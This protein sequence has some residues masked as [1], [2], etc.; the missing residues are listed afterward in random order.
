MREG[1]QGRKRD[2]LTEVDYEMKKNSRWNS[3]KIILL[4]MILAS[5]TAT[6]SVFAKPGE[7]NGKGSD[8]NNGKNGK[9][10]VEIV[11]MA[12][13]ADSVGGVVHVGEDTDT[14]GDWYT[15]GYGSYAHILPGAPEGRMETHIGWWNIQ[16]TGVG[17]PGYWRS[18]PE[19]WPVDF[20]EI[21]GRIYNK[22]Y[23]IFLIYE[24][25]G[26]DKTFDLFEQ[27]VAAKLNIIMQNAY[28]CI[29]PEVTWADIWMVDHPINSSV[30]AGSPEWKEVE[31]AVE[32]ISD[33]NQG[34]LCAPYMDPEMAGLNTTIW[35]GMSEEELINFFGSPPYNWSEWHYEGLAYMKMDAPY[36]DEYVGSP[37]GPDNGN[38]TYSIAGTRVQVGSETIQYP[39]F[40]FM[41]DYAGW[42][43]TPDDHREVYYQN[44]WEEGPGWILMTWD[45]GGERSFPT[46]GYINVTLTFPRG[47]WSMALYAYDYER[48]PAGTW[49]A[50]A[51]QTYRIYDLNGNS[52]VNTTIAGEIFD[53]G[54]YEI[55]EVTAPTDGYTII[56][57]VYNSGGHYPID[58]D[59][60]PLSHTINV[61]L[62]GIF[63]DEILP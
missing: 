10:S 33:Y 53:N 47:N 31:N 49:L 7:N 22:T 39:A 57:Q 13:E 29:D 21:G 25:G 58:S 15:E 3:L 48:A 16:E 45:D 20:I 9:N 12:I 23:A 41:W 54:V 63:I 50:R 44:L 19:A 40:S 6:F 27:L 59:P 52:L 46:N 56:V 2:Y 14:G 61:V 1:A 24:S 30:S 43:E 34:F 55:Y 37:G 51:E 38:I 35:Q 42:S 5:S 8:K 60:F 36:W 62:S 18:H 11:S 26:G 17:T 32:A 28:E 4:V